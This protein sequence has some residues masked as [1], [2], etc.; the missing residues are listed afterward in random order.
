MIQ[1]KYASIALREANAIAEGRKWYPA[2][3]RPA[4]MEMG[5]LRGG[6][7]PHNMFDLAKRRETP[8]QSMDMNQ[9]L[10]AMAMVIAIA[11]DAP[12]STRND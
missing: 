1:R 10:T 11:R 3:T 9:V 12:P 7:Y 8:I 5:W 6:G 4:L 2:L